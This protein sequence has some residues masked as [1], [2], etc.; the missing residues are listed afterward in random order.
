MTNHKKKFL[1]KFSV[2]IKK[3]EVLRL[4][5]KKIQHFILLYKHIE[6][7]YTAKKIR[8][9]KEKYKLKKKRE[10]QGRKMLLYVIDIDGFEMKKKIESER[11]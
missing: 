4:S 11:E 2:L 9:M 8:R 1:V 10:N 5:K 3:M 7:V 6:S